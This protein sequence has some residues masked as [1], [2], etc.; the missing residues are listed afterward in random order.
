MRA[1]RRTPARRKSTR[2]LR[3]VVAALALTLAGF[4]AAEDSPAPAA[5]AAGTDAAAALL[6]DGHAALVRGE[7]GEGIGLL[8]RLEK[9][10][11]I[12]SDY[13]ALLA[14]RGLVDAK[15]FADARAVVTRFEAQGLATPLESD[16]E[17]VRG[18]AAA[19]EGD[20]AA[21]RASFE[22]A[23]GATSDPAR[24]ASLLRALAEIDE[25]S[26]ASEAAG[27][28]WL[29]LWRDLPAQAAARG[30]GEH[31]DSLERALGRTLRSADDARVRG[32]QL[33]DA[34]LRE[35]SVDAYDRALAAGLA[36]EARREAERRRGEALFGLRRYGEAQAAFETLGGDPAAQ[37]F[38]ARAVA[39]RGDVPG[40]VQ[41]LLAQA[42]SLP[43]APG[44]RARW[45]AALLLD[46]ENETD[47]AVPLFDQVAREA[48]DP[49]LRV[50]AL[51]RL[52]WA[53][54]RA[55]RSGEARRRL[56]EMA[57]VAADPVVRLQAR[58]WAARARGTGE[59]EEAELGALVREAPFTYYGWRARERLAARS[60]L[61][62][63]TGARAPLPSGARALGSRD[64]ER[65]RI[66][67]R[68]GLGSLAYEEIA[69]LADRAA[70]IDD[71]LFVAGAYQEA[72]AYDRA[73]AIVLKRHAEDLPRGVTDGQ[74]GLW[75]A[76]WP[77]AF[78]DAVG[79][80]AKRP[81]RPDPQLVWALMREESSFRPA[82]VSPAGAEGLLQLMPETAARVAREAG[83]DL[84]AAERL[85][86]PA[87]NVRLGTAY[88][89]SLVE[90]FGGRTSAAVGSYNAGPEAVARW[91]RERPA[92]ADDE[93]VESIP[94]DETRN[95]VK[96]VLRSRHVYRELYANER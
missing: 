58:Y 79:E 1:G 43:G 34:G 76:A 52:A 38:A 17:R 65:A 22:Q 84:S 86:D 82:V 3:T 48:E 39:R 41:R 21:A 70:G 75:R 83:L 33:F 73:L 74:A 62:K 6:R 30:S 5:A 54:Y 51:W 14:A 71:L 16:L 11:P 49:S 47:R 8:E 35:A 69:R 56:A 77:R 37:V 28:R 90:R 59:Q 29:R 64:T 95:Y 67:V 53:D 80:A 31:L 2:A 13:A 96:R 10:H 60:A 46:G 15:R 24:V 94:Y 66:V 40:A 78:A 61:P 27:A 7:T 19:G 92:L 20:V 36:G 55:G 9:Q 87:I 72:G 68:A 45:F 88:L 26:G 42:G 4:A 32:D 89:G 25:T 18:E 81:G 91:L 50:G 12:V 93:W 85:A 23:L 63:P 44:A 57:E